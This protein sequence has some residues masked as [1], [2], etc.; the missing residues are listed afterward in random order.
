MA[1]HLFGACSFLINIVLLLV[2]SFQCQTNRVAKQINKQM[3]KALCQSCFFVVICKNRSNL[4]MNKRSFLTH[5]IVP[6]LY[7]P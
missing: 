1:R 2:G 4:C 3:N 7:F 5:L 6:A